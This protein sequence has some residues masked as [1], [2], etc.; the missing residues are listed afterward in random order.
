MISRRFVLTAFLSTMVSALA[1]L[2]AV[3]Q[4]T[5]ASQFIRQ[6]GDQAIQVMQTPNLSLDAREAKFRALLAQGFDIAFISQFVLGRSW[7]DATTEQRDSYQ[8]LFSEYILRVYSS[9]FGGY[10][11]EKLAI[12]EERS[13][14]QQDVMVS[15]RID[16]PSGPPIMA[17]WR[18]RA[19]GGGHKIIDV[20]VEGVSM[21]ATQRSE[22]GAIIK[23]DGIDGLI[24]LLDVRTAKVSATAAK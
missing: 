22:F 14:G 15:T 16:R 6:L 11:G 7:R 1:V 17:E 3:A 18:V 9:R 8:Q 5:G 4:G 10:S 20:M 13:A 12:V 19:G 21:A 2:P 24:H 23:R